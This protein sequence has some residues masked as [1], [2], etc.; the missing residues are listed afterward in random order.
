MTEKIGE[1]P[2]VNF[3]T[4]DE[5][6]LLISDQLGGYSFST[7]GQLA[8]HIGDAQALSDRP[9]RVFYLRDNDTGQ[10]WQITEQPSFSPH[11]RFEARHGIGYSIFESEANGISF[12]ATVFVP[13]S[14]PVEIWEIKITNQSK[15]KRRL[16][17]YLV[18]EWA[19]T[20]D[21]CRG[22]GNML[23]ATSRHQ[24]ELAGFASLDHALDSFETDPTIFFGRGRGYLS[25]QALLDGRLS[26][27]QGALPKNG[28]GVL[29]KKISLGAG[30]NFELAAILGLASSSRPVEKA[31]R[32]ARQYGESTARRQALLALGANWRQISARHL[33]K[34][35][36]TA[37]NDRYNRWASYQ[38]LLANRHPQVTGY[39][40]QSVLTALTTEIV[41]EQA[42]VG[43]LDEPILSRDRLRALLAR[44][45]S[46]GWVVN[47]WALA[48][49][50]PSITATVLLLTALAAYINETGDQDIL[51]EHF[52]F[53]DSGSGSGLVH[54]NRASNAIVSQ[55]SPRHLLPRHQESIAI[56]GQAITALEQVLPI[57][58]SAGEHHQANAL[59]KHIEQLRSGINAEWSSR[60]F[61]REVTTVKR[62]SKS[63]KY[64][65]HDL[66]AE[67][68]AILSRSTDPGRVKNSLTLIKKQLITRFGPVDFAPPYE[69]VEEGNPLSYDQPG[70][71]RNGAVVTAHALLLARALAATGDG[72]ALVRLLTTDG[73]W[74]PESISLTGEK[75]V[76]FGSSVAL[77]WQK[78]VL[79]SLAGVTAT[80]GGLKID[81]CLPRDWRSIEVNRLFRGAEYHIRISNPLRVCRGIDR[82]IVDGSRLTGSVI[83]PF[84]SGSHMVEVFLG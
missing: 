40:Q 28:V 71:G 44:Q 64:H 12:T 7:S 46:D 83:T 25:P 51:K 70:T 38:G 63:A 9:G 4:N 24:P 72:D 78:T 37:I 13:P 45:L 84:R 50:L 32:L 73:L 74:L 10:V 58:E 69:V 2:V 67:L 23:I 55:V 61:P 1:A 41:A 30:A 5:Y 27:S 54:L 82:I 81:P 62:S 47:D 22:V 6:G 57:L 65:H 16:S 8:T 11:E 14:D 39:G 20:F 42:V 49:L 52:N 36:V 48:E 56:T 18:L 53:A 59:T 35:P 15:I 26:R 76:C 75:G 43:L 60:G 21:Y 68:W 17:L 79:E 31:K 33:L 29:E 19:E 77:A 66:L 34:S 80:L 3:L